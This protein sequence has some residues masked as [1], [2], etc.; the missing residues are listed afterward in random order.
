MVSHGAHG[1]RTF[2]RAPRRPGP[3][4]PAH[5]LT[6]F[7]IHT[8]TRGRFVRKRKSAD[9]RVRTAR[10]AQERLYITRRQKQYPRAALQRDRPSPA[11]GPAAPSERL[12]SEGRQDGALPCRARFLAGGA[13][14]GQ[15]RPSPSPLD[16]EGGGL[17][18]N[19]DLWP[20]QARVLLLLGLHLGRP[21]LEEQPRNLVVA[22]RMRPE[23]RPR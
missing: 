6:L 18:A 22:R 7:S 2:S 3:L 21:R 15:G 12:G 11:R 13:Q 14:V 10:K 4:S 9:S 23:Q 16:H 20:S 1:A 17:H 8:H 19:L 5:T